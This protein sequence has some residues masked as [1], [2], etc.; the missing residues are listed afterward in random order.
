MRPSPSDD[1]VATTAVEN[2]KVTGRRH[3]AKT[4]DLDPD[5]VREAAAEAG[6]VDAFVSH[7]WGAPFA[8]L[9]AALAHVLTD[10]QRV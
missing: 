9:V 4:S 7:T 6:A 2:G 1:P 5:P 3:A 8:D 10:H